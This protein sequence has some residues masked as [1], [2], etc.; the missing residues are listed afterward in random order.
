MKGGLAYFSENDINKEETFAVCATQQLMYFNSLPRK[1]FPLILQ[2][3][4]GAYT[5]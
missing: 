5:A 1:H 3:V 2:L 4:Q